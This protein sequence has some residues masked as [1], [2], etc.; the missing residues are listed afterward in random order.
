M[1]NKQNK[2]IIR[3]YWSTL[4]SGDAKA[5]AAFWA[6]KVINHGMERSRDE[7]ERLHESLVQVYEHITIH[8]MV[9][10]GDWVA[11]RITA[12][13]RH[14]SQ[15]TVPFDS[16]IYQLTKPDGR[17][18]TFQHIHLFRIIDEKIAEHWANRDDLGAARQLG[19]ELTPVKRSEGP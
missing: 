6:T 3:Q 13:G 10:E 12:Q 11:C 1:T 14:K 19:L 15:P 5:S 8:E 2:D 9:A 16:G 7:V 17:S 18:F 4:N